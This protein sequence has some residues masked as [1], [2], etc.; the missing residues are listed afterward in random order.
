MGGNVNFGG[1]LEC[2]EVEALGQMLGSLGCIRFSICLVDKGGSLIAIVVP[3]I[4]FSFLVKLRHIMG[5]L[6]CRRTF[7][8][9]MDCKRRRGLG[10][11][12]DWRG[13]GRPCWRLGEEVCCSVSPTPLGTAVLLITEVNIV[14][15]ASWGS[16]LP[17]GLSQ[18]RWD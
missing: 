18:G 13:R 17:G 4:N 12:R 11:S 3:K 2:W 14:T 5:R 10:Y 9:R 15:K 16:P 6:N 8:G 7:R 1:L